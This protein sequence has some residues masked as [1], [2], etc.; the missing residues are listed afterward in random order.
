LWSS[1]EK[2]LYTGKEKDSSGLYYY[3]ARYYDPEI[4]RFITRD[5]QKGVI[6]N[7][8]SLN[9]FTYCY[10]NPMCYADPDGRAPKH[11]TDGG[12]FYEEES[13][14]VP[15]YDG[16]GNIRLPDIV[17][18][19]GS[20]GY[21]IW[22]LATHPVAAGFLGGLF[23]TCWVWNWFID[24]VNEEIFIDPMY[25]VQKE[26]YLPI[27]GNEP[28]WCR[29]IIRRDE[30][31]QILALEIYD[32]QNNLVG[33]CTTNQ[34]GEIVSGWMMRLGKYWIFNLET[35]EW[36]EAPDGWEPGNPLPS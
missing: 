31:S 32:S 28:E 17:W 1:S 34:H 5:T 29:I 11:T 15:L 12:G 36:E 30:Y 3:G 18:S 7:S 9:R 25:E 26:G 8:Q 20:L 35:G 2:H 13:D 19:A 23:F 4:G 22:M 24:L 16:K 6:W 33:V 21:W 14:P 10:N 27:H